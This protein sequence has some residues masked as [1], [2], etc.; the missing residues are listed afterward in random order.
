MN[1]TT[2]EDMDLILKVAD[3]AMVEV[4]QFG[5][6]DKMNLVMDIENFHR[7][8]PLDLP[9]LADV[10]DGTFHHDV[11]GIWNH[12]DRQGDTITGGFVP[13]CAASNHRN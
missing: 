2:R 6:S 5:R 8:C 3:R 1:T 13:R 7:L 11:I 10:S 9:R 4:R 12:Y